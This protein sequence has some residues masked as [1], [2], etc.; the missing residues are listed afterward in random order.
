MEKAMATHSSVLAWRIPGKAEPGGLPSMGWHR[1]RHDWSDVA[2]AEN[3]DLSVG[4]TW[5][6]SAVFPPEFIFCI[7]KRCTVEQHKFELHGST[8]MWN[9]FHCKYRSS[10]R[11]MVGWIHGCAEDREKPCKLAHFQ[12]Q[13]RV[14]STWGVQRY[15]RVKLKVHVCIFFLSVDRCFQPSQPWSPS[16]RTCC[17]HPRFASMF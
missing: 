9:F 6:N 13:G 14:A 11:S 4:H 16:L 15:R 2:A 3:L 12:L 10:I 7:S 17:H 5:S 8:C 1:V